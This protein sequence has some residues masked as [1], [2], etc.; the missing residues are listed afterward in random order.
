MKK[1]IKEL[2]GMLSPYSV[3]WGEDGEIVYVSDLMCKLWGAV[4]KPEKIK[5]IVP[6]DSVISAALLPEIT[7]VGLQMTYADKLESVVRGEVMLCG[8]YY[9]LNASPSVLSIDELTN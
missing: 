7:H 5:I 2:V 9:I 3:V 1:V 8:E 6:F 4:L